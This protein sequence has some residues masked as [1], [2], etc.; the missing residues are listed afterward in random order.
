VRTAAPGTGQLSRSA[1]DFG[2]NTGGPAIKNRLFWYGGFNPK[3]AGLER[4]AP[5][6]FGARAFGQQDWKS[7]NYNWVGK[8][9]FEP[10][11][12]HHLEG[13]A[14]G[15]PSRD[16][17]AMHRTLVRNDLDA[18]SSLVYGSRNWAVKYN[19]VLTT[20]TLVNASSP[21]TGPTSTRPRPTTLTR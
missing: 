21:P 20:T 14:F 19:G 17:T 9:N 1:Y 11:P 12:N 8:V 6:N 4:Q 15:D 18:T 16:P 2:I 10:A 7:R 13:T 5:V 3:Y